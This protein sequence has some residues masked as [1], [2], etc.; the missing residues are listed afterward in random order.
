VSGPY[1]ALD[2]PVCRTTYRITFD[3]P[4]R[5]PMLRKRNEVHEVCKVRGPFG[6]GALGL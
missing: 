1:F 5:C 4:W 6:R 2:C 3:A